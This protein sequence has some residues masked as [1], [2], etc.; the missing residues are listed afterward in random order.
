M[1]TAPGGEPLCD[2]ER[3]RIAVLVYSDVLPNRCQQAAP[4]TTLTYSILESRSF[5]KGFIQPLSETEAVIGKVIR[6]VGSGEPPSDE[7]SGSNRLRSKRIRCT[8]HLSKRLPSRH[9]L[10]RAASSALETDLRQRAR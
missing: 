7:R 6:W 2:V 5:G 1:P 9:F 8:F 10:M 3:Q 4:G